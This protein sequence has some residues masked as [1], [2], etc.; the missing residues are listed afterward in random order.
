MDHP[1]CRPH[2]APVLG[3]PHLGYATTP[4]YQ[5]YVSE[6]VEDITAYLTGTP[7]SVPTEP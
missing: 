3:T 1:L 4:N 7:V 6:A 5:A 2:I